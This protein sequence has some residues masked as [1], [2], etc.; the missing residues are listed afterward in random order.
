MGD[1]DRA[2][3]FTNQ[4]ITAAN[5]RSQTI[6]LTLAYQL[7]GSAIVADPTFAQAHYLLGNANSDLSKLY[8]AVANYRL[9]LECAP[10]DELKAKILHNMGWRL[11]GLGRTWE[12]ANAVHESLELSPDEHYSWLT[13]SL[14]NGAASN[15]KASVECAR[16]AYELTQ[17]TPAEL[18]PD[19]PGTHQQKP[20]ITAEMALAF[21][22]L[23]DGQ[24]REG[25][26][27]FEARFAYKLHAFLRYPYPK[28]L[29]EPDKTVFL[30]ADQGLGDTLSFARFV[31]AACN[32]AK[33][34]HAVIQPELLRLFQH[35]FLHIKNL[36]LLPSPCPF[37][38]ADAW[39][40]FVSLPF[41]LQLT[42]EQ[43]RNA[44]HI[45]YPRY[46]LPLNWKVFDRKFHIGIAYAGS[47]LN[48]IDG[49]RN[50]PVTQ[51][52]ELYKVPDVQ[53]Y[54]LQ[55]GE[56]AKEL[57]DAGCAALIRDLSPYIR[58]VVD[59]LSL[60]NDLDLVITVES[61][62]G[63]IAGLAGKETWIPYSYCG[64]DYRLGL[65]GKEPLWYTKHGTFNQGIDQRWEPVF[66][67]IVEALQRK[68]S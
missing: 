25:F 34:V 43:I 63:H 21:A 8:A 39:S 36:N 49:H 61:A 44:P 26:K 5:D 16:R 17:K 3:H 24:Y 33:F 35:A 13:L 42:D 58:D 19:D 48:E 60:L 65:F 12:A 59:T 64:K 7:F 14:I 47:P 10:D 50:I 23:F 32:R 51:F 41:A 9:A 53:L 27:H 54:S 57:H 46:T 20:D 6:N 45:S 4:A 56:K 52:L 40:T 30:V 11:H 2:I 31:E 68:L 29:G 38:E 62:L 22:L 15:P 18:S 37:P 55:V 67:R 1:R 28:W 66:E